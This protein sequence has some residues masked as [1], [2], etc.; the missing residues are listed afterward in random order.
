MVDRLVHAD[1]AGDDARKVAGIERSVSARRTLCPF[2]ECSD[3]LV[4]NARSTCAAV[5]DAWIASR[6]AVTDVTAKPWE[7]SHALAWSTSAL[8]GEK[9]ASHWAA[10]QGVAI[11]RARRVGDR[12]GKRLGAGAVARVQRQLEVD[13]AGLAHGADGIGCGPRPATGCPSTPRFRR[14]RRRRG[15]PRPAVLRRRR[16]TPGPRPAR[17]DDDDARQLLWRERNLHTTGAAPWSRS[18]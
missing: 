8:V 4:L 16:P 7:R 9:R 15:N 2:T 3:R 11:R 12:A 17:G 6:S 1:R 10:V 5:P 14:A 18:C 13:G